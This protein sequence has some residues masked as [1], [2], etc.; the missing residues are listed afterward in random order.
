MNWLRRMANYE[1]P[2][3]GRVGWALIVVLWLFVTAVGFGTGVG[4]GLAILIVG[5][6]LIAGEVWIDRSGERHATFALVW[7][8]SWRIGLGVTAI[9]LGVVGS[10]G[11]AI[12]VPAVLGGWLILSGLVFATLLW[13]QARIRSPLGSTEDEPG[14]EPR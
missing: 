6:A 10:E 3:V 8:L 4:T 13:R 14:R 7:F 5:G 1:R 9:L 12:A 11:W 2:W